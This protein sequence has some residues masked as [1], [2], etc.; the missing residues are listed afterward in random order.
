MSFL[1]ILVLILAYLIGS[2]PFGLIVGK[3]GYG[4]D[5]REHGSGNLGATNTFR[6]LG[7]KAGLF[8]TVADILKGTLAASLPVLLSGDLH[9]AWTLIAGMVAA[10]G[11]MY[12]IF[13]GFRGGKAVATS[14]GVLLFYSPL[15]FLS[16]LAVFFLVLYVSKY[17]SLSSMVTALYTLVYT[18]FTGDAAL[19]IIVAILATFVFYRHRAN[20]KRI[21]NKTEPKVKWL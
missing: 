1:L 11:H 16:M 19:M 12:P 4:I 18:I 20:I 7:K 10:V 3:I 9:Q 21:I 14:G 5:I 6:V 8:V 15:L 2:I 17:V 13:A